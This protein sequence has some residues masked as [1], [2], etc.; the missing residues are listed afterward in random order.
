MPTNTAGKQGGELP[1]LAANFMR[2]PIAYNSPGITSAST[3]KIG[4][5]PIG[6]QVI[7][8]MI[9]VT[10]AF[11]DTGTD[12]LIVG[13]AGA[14]NNLAQTA[15]S[16]L[17]TTGGYWVVRGMDVNYAAETD[18]NA[19]YAGQNSNADAGEGHVSVIFLPNVG[20]QA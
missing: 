11:T 3:Y 17:A 12:T 4:A 19:Q 16:D 5:M 9:K 7:G 2:R 13:N 8:T 1:F 10:T 18:I 14:T 15:D 6:A 20:F